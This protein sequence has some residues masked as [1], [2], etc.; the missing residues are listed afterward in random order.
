MGGSGRSKAYWGSV[1]VS[2]CL[3]RGIREAGS[4]GVVPERG[5]VVRLKDACALSARGR[6]SRRSVVMLERR[7]CMLAVDGS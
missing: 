7:D 3:R 4:D 6:G 5:W 1:G 2:T